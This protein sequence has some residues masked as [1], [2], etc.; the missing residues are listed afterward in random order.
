[1]FKSDKYTKLCEKDNDKL[2]TCSFAEELGQFILNYNKT[3]SLVVGLCGEWGSGKTSIIKTTLNYIENK[4]EKPN[5]N[6]WIKLVDLLKKILRKKEENKDPIIIEFNP[7]NFSNQDQLIS[8][9]FKEMIVKLGKTDYD[10][11][12]KTTQK[13][14]VYAN[15][16]ESVSIVFPPLW[17]LIRAIKKIY[18][19]ITDFSSYK[20][21]DLNGMKKELDD[22]LK[23]QH[24]KI[25][26]FID[27]IDRLNKIEIRQIFQL[28]KSLADFPNTIYMLAFDKKV[29]VNSLRQIQKDGNVDP[30]DNLSE[31]QGLKYLEKVVQ[32]IFEVPKISRIEV[33][34]ILKEQLRSLTKHERWDKNQWS[35]YYQSGIKYLFKNIRDINRYFNTLIFSFKLLKDEVNLPDL[36]AITAIQVFIPEMYNDIKN[37]KDIFAGDIHDI[38]ISQIETQQRINRQKF[39]E[40]MINRNNKIPEEKILILLKSLFPNVVSIYDDKKYPDFPNNIDK[41]RICK[42]D[43]FD[44]Y[45]RLTVPKWEF[46]Q[47]EFNYLIE[48]AD[49]RESF[50]DELS[51]LIEDKK[52]YKFLELVGDYNLDIP[53]GSIKTIIGAVMDVSDLCPLND[54]Y[55]GQIQIDGILSDILMNLGQ[56]LNQKERFNTFKNAINISKSLY[57]PIY[58]IERIDYYFS[59][60]KEQFLSTK[61]F[62]SLKKVCV[63]K[64]ENWAES[65]KLIETKRLLFILNKW[66]EWGDKN[67]VKTFMN[68]LDEN[69]LVKLISDSSNRSAF[70]ETAAKDFLRAMKEIM[71]LRVLKNK[72]NNI[73]TS[74]LDDTEKNFI[75]KLLKILKD[76]ILRDNI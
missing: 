57:T 65:G 6:L 35:Y 28:V 67:L 49:N 10:S 72:L 68:D 16:F 24:H 58:T 75:N 34:S 55:M 15:F 8:Q 66:A 38:A 18:S 29:V 21:N 9:F 32:V 43:M 74:T 30:S 7:W 26:I 33:K 20:L 37:N 42:L 22:S 73:D 71:D 36:F 40:N 53:E 46:S 54:P 1:M 25:I 62:D 23:N 17:V 13:L 63:K 27:D 47:R 70:L 56:N 12:K 61:E 19:S 3:D 2:G 51:E 48:T 31:D 69:S 76:P 44:T 45:F 52:I 5:K 64:I 11:L 4:Y 50:V 60:S 59:N 41:K 39:V 14:E